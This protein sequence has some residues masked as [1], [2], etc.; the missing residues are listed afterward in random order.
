[1]PGITTQAVIGCGDVDLSLS[2]EEMQAIVRAALADVGRVVALPDEHYDEMW[3][4]GKA[5]Y[6]LGGIIED[7][8]ELLI[9][10]P[11]LRSISETHG[12]LI[13]RFGFIR[14][15]DCGAAGG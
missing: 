10:A 2:L 6:K 14:P 4:G 9:Y 1:M 11:H 3:V 15:C 8:G 7:G 5:S 13:E 12:R